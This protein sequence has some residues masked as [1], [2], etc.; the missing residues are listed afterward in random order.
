MVGCS[1]SA[2][3]TYSPPAAAKCSAACPQQRPPSPHLTKAAALARSSAS[4]RGTADACGAIAKACS[5]APSQ[6]LAGCC[7]RL[8]SSACRQEGHAGH[9]TNARRSRP[10]DSCRCEAAAGEAAAR[11]G[12][13]SKTSRWRMTHAAISSVAARH[14]R[15]SLLP[16]PPPASRPRC[17]HATHGAPH[18]TSRSS[19]SRPPSPRA[20]GSA[21]SLS[22]AP[23][24]GSSLR[25]VRPP[26]CCFGA[27]APHSSTA[28]ERSRESS[29]APPP[30]ASEPNSPG[31]GTPLPRPSAAAG[32]PRKP[33]RPAG[34]TASSDSEIGRLAI[35]G[36]S[37]SG[38]AIS[39]SMATSRSST[40][41]SLASPSSASSAPIRCAR[42]APVAAGSLPRPSSHRATRRASCAALRKGPASGSFAT[43]GAPSSSL[44]SMCAWP[45]HTAY[46]S[47]LARVSRV[48]ANGE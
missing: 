17:A 42:S 1:L 27:T 19:V 37:S 46:A 10:V 6:L 13:P 2:S 11:A 44:S 18:R 31:G 22:S 35:P 36:S 16:A 40:L 24:T 47:G 15:A 4:T 32:A 34:G 30:P 41:P 23:R 43:G 38:R 21:P 14:A 29:S 45:Q 7:S 28:R 33:E 20:A 25:M 39:R 3:Q 9:G 12:S 8:L 48:G 5:G 26:S